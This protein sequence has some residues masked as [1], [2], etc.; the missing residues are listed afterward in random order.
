MQSPVLTQSPS[1]FG[2]SGKPV[3]AS[4]HEMCRLVSVALHMS[5][6]PLVQVLVCIWSPG[7]QVLSV[8]VAS[9]SSVLFQSPN[10]LGQ[11]GK[12][13]PASTQEMFCLVSA[14]VHMSVVP[15]VQ[16]LVCN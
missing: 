3:P 12:L 10:C 14:S 13:V 1:C 9:H 2:Q 8:P 4:E 7:P 6:V 11:S 16:A 5:V 15:S